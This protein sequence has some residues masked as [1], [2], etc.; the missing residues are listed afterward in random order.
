[1][2]GESE[3]KQAAEKVARAFRAHGWI[4]EVFEGYAVSSPWMLVLRPGSV[5]VELEWAQDGKNEYAFHLASVDDGECVEKGAG[6][7]WRAAIM[8]EIAALCP[9]ECEDPS[10]DLA[11]TRLLAREFPA[12]FAEAMAAI[13][14]ECGDPIPEDA[15]MVAASLC[16]GELERIAAAADSREWRAL[17]ARIAGA[18]VVAELEAAGLAPRL[19]DAPP[20]R[21]VETS[22]D[23]DALADCGIDA[24]KVG[25]L[26]AFLDECAARYARMSEGMMERAA[27]AAAEALGLDAAAIMPES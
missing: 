23:S 9:A 22:F 2:K 4:A 17:V 3:N 12:P 20:R 7:A 24:S 19:D 1:M 26:P 18:K 10:V 25:D 5:T 8:A 6:E 11:R 16:K 27:W 21:I 15:E 13:G 14:A